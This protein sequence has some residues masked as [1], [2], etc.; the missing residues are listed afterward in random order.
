MDSPIQSGPPA[1]HHE[2]LTGRTI[3]RFAV[4]QRLGAGGMGEVYLA[5]DT[6]LK[7]PVALKRL[8]PKLK[9][10]AHFRE[11]FMREAE[12]ASRLSAQNIAHL[13]DAFEE[14]GEI[15]LVMEYVEGQTLRH[16]LSTSIPLG[17]FFS[18]A[19][20]CAEALVAA[21]E[22][23]IVHRDI[24]P[25]NIMLTPAG[26]LK[27][28]DFGVA[29]HVPTAAEAGDSATMDTREYDSSAI[30]G[31]PAY[32][33]PEVLLQQ[34]ADTRADI[35]SLGILFYEALAG[36]HP[37]LA[38]SVI[39]T[40]DRIL[41]EEPQPISFYNRNVPPELERVVAKMMA[42]D[43]EDRYATAADLLVD[44]KSLARAHSSGGPTPVHLTPAH[45]P[46]AAEGVAP[47]PARW[48]VTSLL[49]AAAV[50]VPLLIL[51][52][53]LFVPALRERLTSPDAIRPTLPATKNVAVLPFKSIGESVQTQAYCDGLTETLT[54]KLTQL[55]AAH[56]LQVVPSSEVRARKVSSPEEARRELGV[57]L[58]L[59]GTYHQVG[60]TVRVNFILVDTSSLRQLH[61][62]SFDLSMRDPFAI[63]NRVVTGAVEMLGLR[64]SS[65]E[66]RV[67]AA[68]G[69]Q[70]PTAHQLYTEARGYLLNYDQPENIEQAIGLFQRALDLDPNFA[71]ARA[72]LGSAYW[73]K[74]ETTKQAR[75]VQ[76]ARAACELSLALAP[77]LAAGEIC[78]GRVET[79]TGKYEAAVRRFQRALEIEPTNDE[80]YRSLAE[81]YDKLLRPD[82]A[83]KTY[84][85]AIE[86]RPNYWASYNWLGAFYYGKGRF[87]DAAEMFKRVVALAP[88]S[89]RGYNNLGA[90][91]L[92]LGREK[93]A[94]PA[95][96][97]SL[98]IRPNASAASNL[99]TLYFF[100]MS[101]YPRA[102][103]AF[104][105]A[106]TF[107]QDDYGLWGNLG[108]ARRWAGNSDGAREAYQKAATLAEAARK[109][110]PRD[111]RVHADLAEYYA[112]LGEPARARPLMEQALKLD[113][114]NHQIL[115]QAAVLHEVYLKQRDA[116]LQFLAEAVRQNHPWPEIER[117]PGLKDL[118]TDPRFAPLRP[119]K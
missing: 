34:D 87:A 39:A 49:L 96:E 100:S 44:L 8:A 81:T 85:R 103:R 98:S 107:N 23:Q 37:F 41:H 18:I 38:S 53:I 114:K 19:L 66:N 86:L 15:F 3:G 61:A 50:A 72:G 24:K 76:P 28:L 2:D 79:G 54:A 58:V 40:S 11:R 97:K 56:A 115:F 101:D 42:K 108:A 111:A 70:V 32:M 35:F 94:I 6:R 27:I 59:S 78:L 84:K 105:Q 33:A 63:E 7:R 75:W 112:S 17:E 102:A 88:E 68:S 22:R 93:E 62:D 48:P 77:G 25:E 60:E 71:L 51:L 109:L 104:E 64:T 106:L 55:T 118:R 117:A 16:R 82:D 13:Y 110:N 67:L 21:H 31:T 99:G 89:A 47:L 45:A 14:N 5:E 73:K 20:Q 29:R 10:E 65:A 12:R 43:R 46:R 119:A 52:A 95:F 113:P 36:R 80:A 116:A 92:S 91:F 4:R 90:A 30:S 9:Y 83:E 74:F 57:N 69:T 26:R 1:P